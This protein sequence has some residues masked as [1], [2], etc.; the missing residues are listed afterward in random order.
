MPDK[1]ICRICGREMNQHAEKFVYLE[2]GGSGSIEEMHTCPGCGGSDS[3]PSRTSPR[4][5]EQA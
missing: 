3:R 5:P 4:P 2:D 1:M